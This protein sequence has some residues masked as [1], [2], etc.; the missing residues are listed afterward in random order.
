MARYYALNC[1]LCEKA[2]LQ[3]LVGYVEDK[4]LQEL[5]CEACGTFNYKEPAKVSKK[6]RTWP[7]HND[8]AD[9]TFESESHEQ[10]YVKANNLEVL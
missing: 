2:T 3:K 6:K 1:S 5:A 9:V 10:K 7:Y 4:D 8:S